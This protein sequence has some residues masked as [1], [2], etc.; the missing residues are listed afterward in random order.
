MP[1][2]EKMT[3][4]ELIELLRSLQKE[5]APA[6]SGEEV[7]SLVH[8]LKVH[9]VELEM[10]NRELRETR[11][12]LEDTLARYADLYEFAP[13]AYF[14]LTEKGIIKEVNLTGAATLEMKRPALIYLPFS[15]FLEKGSDLT[16]F[17]H[18]KECL[19]TGR[20]I[21]EL[22]L[23]LK[24]KRLHVQA[25]S[26]LSETPLQGN[27]VRTALTDITERK[28]AEEFAVMLASEKAAREESEKARL[29]I[30]E[31]EAVYRAVGEAIPFGIW[32]AGPDGGMRYL[33]RSFLEAC[34][35]TME[36]CAGHGWLGCLAS[37]DAKRLLRHWKECI[38]E[39]SYC[40]VDFSI[41]GPDG[42]KHDVL[43]RGIPIRGADG[44][45]LQWAGVNIDIT[46][47]KEME[48][49]LSDEKER[50]AVTLGSIAECVITTDSMG[51]VFFMNK[52]CERLTGVSQPEAVGKKTS[53][54]V[55]LWDAVESRRIDDPERAVSEIE[56]SSVFQGRLE[57]ADRH[58]IRH[59]VAGRVAPL[60]GNLGEIIGNV[61]VFR[62]I[63]A[64]KMAEEEVLK[65]MKLESIHSLANGIARGFTN[66]LT[67]LRGN[68]ELAVDDYPG[69]K[70]RLVESIKLVDSM[71][72]LSHQLLTFSA[73][74]KPV[75][76][77][78]F[79]DELVRDVAND[80]FEGSGVEHRVRFPKGIWPVEIDPGQMREAFR[81]IFI[82]SLEALAAGGSVRV[83]ARNVDNRGDGVPFLQKGKYVRI[84][85]T[86]TGRGIPPEELERVFDPF[87]ST[88]GKRSGLG[89]TIARSI[90]TNHGGFITIASTPGRCTSVDIF[91]PASPGRTQL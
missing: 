53:E 16:F 11:D 67:S 87:Y 86:D 47:R 76:E 73:G 88:K 13:V 25:V 34:G 12:Q 8:E 37:G 49:A 23:R 1:R 28:K 69:S 3:K 21:C 83:S 44:K 27:L 64:L 48:N 85:V 46:G 71:H 43:S 60:K 58:G 15:V 22:T 61:V 7:Q 63:T 78:V 79:I 57:L 14:T 70:E 91:V 5:I 62:D 90:I 74:L 30:E 10:Q 41:K 50:L 56:A 36:E 52:E 54:V 9:Q 77:F 20:A 45:I 51:K 31:S 84:N 80:V 29:Q 65:T 18:I 32:I 66:L 40:E 33:S 35:K 39:G 19:Q 38:G 26:T 24:G 82:N 4:D 59:K 68:I 6:K 2:L 55:E 81:N 17:A 75:K 89:L 72:S 42:T